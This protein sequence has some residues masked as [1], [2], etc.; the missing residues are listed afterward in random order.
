MHRLH[1]DHKNDTTIHH[2]CYLNI[3]IP[4]LLTG[5]IDMFSLVGKNWGNH[6]VR[7]I[8]ISIWGGFSG[9][10]G[11]IIL[12]GIMVPLCLRGSCELKEGGTC[13]TFG[14]CVWGFWSECIGDRL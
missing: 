9:I 13:V 5:L 4:A 11:L 8:T 12:F 3:Y 1:G 7:I 14:I 2:G 6:A 10:V